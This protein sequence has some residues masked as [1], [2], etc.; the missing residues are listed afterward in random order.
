MNSNNNDDNDYENY[1][2]IE[3]YHLLQSQYLLFN[4]ILVIRKKEK[5]S[6][7][8]IKKILDFMELLGWWRMHM[9]NK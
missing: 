1:N 4:V 7:G 8:R 2:N 5:K 3:K 9:K 6:V